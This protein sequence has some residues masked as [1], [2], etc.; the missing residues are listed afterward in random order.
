MSRYAGSCSERLSLDHYHMSAVAG[1]ALLAL[2]FLANATDLDVTAASW[3]P[4]GL[5]D[6][7]KA[8]LLA[9]VKAAKENPYEITEP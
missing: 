8:D 4:E 1:Q 6:S 9:C 5:S 7:E 3:W 2:N